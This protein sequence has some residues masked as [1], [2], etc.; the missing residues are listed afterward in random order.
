MSINAPLDASNPSQLTQADS[1]PFVNNGEVLIGSSLTGLSGIEGAN[2]N[3]TATA[4]ADGGSS[5]SDTPK[6]PTATVA[7]SPFVWAALAA[8]VILALH[9]AP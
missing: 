5:A 8:I 4:G 1:F 7:V 2:P 3:A 6:L 9:L